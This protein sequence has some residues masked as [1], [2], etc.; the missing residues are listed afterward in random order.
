[1]TLPAADSS[2]VPPALFPDLASVW[3]HEAPKRAL[4]VAAAGGHPLLLVGPTGAGK[5]LLARCLP[6]LLPP[7]TAE[8]AQAVAEVYARTGEPPPPGRPVRVPG[9]SLSRAGLL[10]GGAAG[11]R[12]G[13]AG[14]AVHGVLILD[15]LAL[16]H[17]AT[18]Q[19]L[20]AVLD[21]G[22][23][24]P[25]WLTA[26]ALRPCPCGRLAPQDAACGCPPALVRRH[27]ARI[28]GALLDRFE[29]QV[30]V[31]ALTRREL[32]S[33]GETSAAVAARVAGARRFRDER[34]GRAG[35][36]PAELDPDCRSLLATAVERLAL[37]ARA[38]ARVQQVARTIADLAGS[39]E[40]R[41]THLAEAIQYR[42]RAAGWV[43]PLA[44]DGHPPDRGHAAG[45]PALPGSAAAP[46]RS[47]ARPVSGRGS[48]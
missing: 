31:P 26:A 8:E 4:E 35:C 6:G 47:H 28:D 41:A 36:R 32:A 1:M 46:P 9:P 43:S 37:S 16:L 11:G 25:P 44:E 39:P 10:G 17:R 40:V 21:G 48:R 7:L 12:P 14:L 18:R 23:Q 19:V 2:P 34:A 5:S 22:H 20:C 13:E 45:S 42:G 3:G 24:A 30:E 15:D 33:A 38:V 27:L 29:I